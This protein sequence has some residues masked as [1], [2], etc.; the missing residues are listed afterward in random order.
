MSDDKMKDGENHLP[1]KESRKRFV[2][3]LCPETE[4]TLVIGAKATRAAGPKAVLS[5]GNHI[6]SRMG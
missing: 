5:T 4:D 2:Y 3:P 6:F 1:I